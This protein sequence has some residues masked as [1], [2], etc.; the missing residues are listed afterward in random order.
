MILSAIE[1]FNARC[2]ARYTVPI[3][4]PP[5]KASI[6]NFSAMVRPMSGST[7]GSS[8]SRD[9]TFSLSAKHE[10]PTWLAWTRTPSAPLE[11][12]DR[13]RHEHHGRRKEGARGA[14]RPLREARGDGRAN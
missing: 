13:A 9:D 14:V 12:R 7:A 3:E 10:H 2:R 8:I 4:P 6:W 11:G 5:T 1:R